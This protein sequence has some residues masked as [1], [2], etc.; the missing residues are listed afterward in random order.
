MAVNSASIYLFIYTA[1]Q[2]GFQPNYSETEQQ[3]Y[4]G[5]YLSFK[6]DIYAISA[7]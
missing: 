5:Y 6:R 1:S 2:W 7:S 4:Y 3:Y